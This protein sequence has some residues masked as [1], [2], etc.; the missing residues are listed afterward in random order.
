[1]QTR[2]SNGISW[3]SPKFGGLEVRAHYGLGERDTDP[4]T[5][6]N[7]AGLALLYTAGPLSLAGW[8]HD[9]KVLA[10][11]TT[12]GVKEWGGGGIYNFGVARVSLGFDAGDP[13]G[14]RKTSFTSIGASTAVG[15]GTVSVQY[16]SMKEAASSDWQRST[17]HSGGYST[18]LL[19]LV[20][21]RFRRS[22]DAAA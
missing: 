1:M 16:L 15:A 9:R 20:R 22:S 8:Y 3:K 10:G 14:P 6:G 11:T 5:A 18:H 7:A 12:T 17:W 21:Y 4:K 13:E 2:V 19:S